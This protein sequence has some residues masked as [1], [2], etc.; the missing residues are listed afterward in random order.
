MQPLARAA[1]KPCRAVPGGQPSPGVAFALPRDA[2]RRP[3]PLLARTAWLGRGSTPT[4][5]D[6]EQNCGDPAAAFWV[7]SQLGHHFLLE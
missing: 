2:P 4:L 7:V 6:H 3:V 1:G 5:P